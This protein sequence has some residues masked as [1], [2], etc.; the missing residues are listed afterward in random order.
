MSGLFANEVTVNGKIVTSAADKWD[1]TQMLANS[2]RATS[3][4]GSTLQPIYF[5]E[6]GTSMLLQTT[7]SVTETTAGDPMAG[8]W[9]HNGTNRAFI[10]VRGAALFYSPQGASWNGWYEQNVN[11]WPTQELAPGWAGAATADIDIVL[12]NETITIYVDKIYSKSIPL[13]DV[14]PNLASNAQI[15][16]GLVAYTDGTRVYD[17]TFSNIEFTTDA[18]TVDAFLAEKGE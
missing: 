17:M 5:A 11:Y 7:V 1:V 16:F 14:M 9:L 4:L 13:S 6:T 12:A 15:A 10:G 8:V 2:M 18:A 3:E